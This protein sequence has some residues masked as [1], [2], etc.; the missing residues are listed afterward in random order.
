MDGEQQQ[1]AEIRL[2]LV[3]VTHHQHRKIHPTGGFSDS[4]HVCWR[5]CPRHRATCPA[6][7]TWLPQKII[8]WIDG[9]KAPLLDF[10]QLIGLRL[11]ILRKFA[12]STLSACHQQRR[13]ALPE[14]ALPGSGEKLDVRSGLESPLAEI[15]ER[16]F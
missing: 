16:K 9:P 11:P 15:A 6:C 8:L 12:V 3:F 13:I 10:Q 2:G 1:P 5:P 7:H 14:Q 4:I